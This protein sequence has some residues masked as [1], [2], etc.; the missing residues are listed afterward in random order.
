M[1]GDKGTVRGRSP[2]G[3]VRLLLRLPILLYR[4]HMRWLLGSRFLL[5]RHIGRKSGM[6]HSTV[7]EIVD[8]VIATHTCIVVSGWGERAQWLKSITVNPDVDVTQGVRTQ[9]ARARRM[10]R[11]EA[12]SALCNYVCRHP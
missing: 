7:L 8:Y 5:L 6:H 9:R 4:V 11:N 2:K 10:R 3:W 1:E 12:E